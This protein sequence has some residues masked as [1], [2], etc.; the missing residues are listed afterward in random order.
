MCVP[1][2]TRWKKWER[3]YSGEFYDGDTHV[4]HIHMKNNTIKMK[5]NERKIAIRWND[6]ICIVTVHTHTHTLITIV[7]VMC[8]FSLLFDECPYTISN[9]IYRFSWGFT[10]WFTVYFFQNFGIFLSKKNAWKQFFQ[11]DFGI[12]FL[13]SVRNLL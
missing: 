8:F 10:V 11:I 12:F 6:T 3:I 13:F 5:R 1:H 7:C 4:V 2:T 9:K